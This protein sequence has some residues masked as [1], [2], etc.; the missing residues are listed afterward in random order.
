MKETGYELNIATIFSF[1]PNEEDPGDVLLDENF[2]TSG[3]D[4][5]SRDFLDSAIV[6]VS[7]LFKMFKNIFYN[8]GY[9]FRI[10]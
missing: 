6:T 9:S 8:L 1:S 5:T 2:D 7:L 10:K 4:Q 3:L